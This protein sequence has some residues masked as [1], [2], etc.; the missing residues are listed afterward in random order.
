MHSKHINM[1]FCKD[2]LYSVNFQVCS[3]VPHYGVTKTNN[4]NIW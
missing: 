4:L 3:I 1:F 2:T